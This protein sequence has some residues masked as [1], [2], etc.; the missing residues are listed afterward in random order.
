MENSSPEEQKGYGGADQG[1][2]QGDENRRDVETAQPDSFQT[3]SSLQEQNHVSSSSTEPSEAAEAST[4]ASALDGDA[5]HEAPTPEQQTKQDDDGDVEMNKEEPK[6]ENAASAAAT[7]VQSATATQHAAAES[8]QTQASADSSHEQGYQE[9]PQQQ[10]LA[11]QQQ[12]SQQLPY[13]TQITGYPPDPVSNRGQQ[14]Q[15]TK[16]TVTQVGQKLLNSV[17]H[18]NYAPPV[19]A[20]EPNFNKVQYIVDCRTK[21]DQEYFCCKLQGCSHLHLKYYTKDQM[22]KLDP[23]NSEALAKYDQEQPPVEQTYPPGCTKVAGVFARRFVCRCLNMGTPHRPGQLRWTRQ[24]LIQWKN[25][26]RTEATW[27]DEEV[28][29]QDEDNAAAIRS[30]EQSGRAAVLTTP[31][32]EAVKQQIVRCMGGSI[33]HSQNQPGQQQGPSG[34]KRNPYESKIT[35]PSNIFK[36]ALIDTMEATGAKHSQLQDLVASPPNAI[37]HWLYGK[38]RIDEFVEKGLKDWLARKCPERWSA[39]LSEVNNTVPNSRDR[40]SE[41]RLLL[42]RYLGLCYDKLPM[43]DGSYSDKGDIDNI[44]EQLFTSEEDLDSFIPPEKEV[45]GRQID[46]GRVNAGR[47]LE[48]YAVVPNEALNQLFDGIEDSLLESDSESLKKLKNQLME[49]DPYRPGADSGMFSHGRI[50]GAQ[51]SAPNNVYMSQIQEET[52]DTEKEEPVKE[53]EGKDERKEHSGSSIEAETNQYQQQ[54][55]ALSHLNEE[56]RE[57]IRADPTIIDKRKHIELMLYHFHVAKETAMKLNFKKSENGVPPELQKLMH[58]ERTPPV[59]LV[60]TSGPQPYYEFEDAPGSDKN[61]YTIPRG[62]ELSSRLLEGPEGM[63]AASSTSI[64][65]GGNWFP[66]GL[67]RGAF[68]RSYWKKQGL[69]RSKSQS[70]ANEQLDALWRVY[71]QLDGRTRDSTIWNPQPGQSLD[72]LKHYCSN[73]VEG[74]DMEMKQALIS[75]CDDYLDYLFSKWRSLVQQF[76]ENFANR[77]RQDAK[78]QIQQLFYELEKKWYSRHQPPPDTASQY[79]GVTQLPSGLFQAQIYKPQELKNVSLGTFRTAEEAAQAYN[80]AAKSVGLAALNDVPSE[81]GGSDSQGQE[82]TAVGKA[83]ENATEAA[84]DG[85]AAPAQVPAESTTEQ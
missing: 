4:T 68:V 79:T 21:E 57:G 59:V 20:A 78:N 73:A 81:T 25:L 42:R 5:R 16:D 11:P 80:S 58:L 84:T 10:H 52:K 27:E 75:E 45:L 47:H 36:Q 61:P 41:E 38:G 18:G 22:L 32:P 77:L 62:N 23:S 13:F 15:V 34:A 43:T 85:A 82:S 30:F 24:Y 7:S 53:E 49:G 44:A 48:S 3:S 55:L 2:A 67:S 14:P 6:E 12:S 69:E 17:P 29:M 35:D 65:L 8:Q 71:V 64:Y 50:G 19:R 74:K 9:Q 83:T 39:H 31:P 76:P 51:Y 72:K 54:L 70:E 63:P 37:Y 40:Y 26:P 66:R 46:L 28:L 60:P 1:A 33:R 56:E